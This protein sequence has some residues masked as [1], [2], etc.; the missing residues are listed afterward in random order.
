VEPIRWKIHQVS[1]LHDHFIDLCMKKGSV[2][3][4]FVK[5]EFGPFQG[6]VSSTGMILW[7]E[8]HLNALIRVCQNIS[9]GTKK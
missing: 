6:S 2:L 9:A 7:V 4:V 3:G 5:V 1:C 8:L